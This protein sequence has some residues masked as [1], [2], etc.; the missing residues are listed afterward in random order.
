L[1]YLRHQQLSKEIIDVDEDED[2]VIDVDKEQ[3]EP[4]S[5]HLIVVPVSVLP[6]WVREFEN[7]APELKVVK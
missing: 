2:D 6:N 5:V 4:H 7:F 1:A 3:P